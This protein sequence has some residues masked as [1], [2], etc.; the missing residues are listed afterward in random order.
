MSVAMATVKKNVGSLFIIF[1]FLIGT[2]SM[3]N[4]NDTRNSVML[5]SL[6]SVDDTSVYGY[7]NI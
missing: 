4:L 5:Y 2:F 3:T 7:V 1:C 6:P